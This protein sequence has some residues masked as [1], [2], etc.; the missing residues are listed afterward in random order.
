MLIRTIPLFL[1]FVLALVAAPTEVLA[2]RG[3]ISIV[4]ESRLLPVAPVPGADGDWICHLVDRT[5]LAFVPL[6]TSPGPYVYGAER[7][8]APGYAAMIAPVPSLKAMGAFPLHVPDTPTLTP[9][10]IAEGFAGLIALGLGL[11]FG[12][13]KFAMRAKRRDIRLQILG[14]GDGPVFQMIDVMCHAALADGKTDPSEVTAIRELARNLTGLDFQDLHITEMVSRA[15]RLTKPRDFVQFGRGL[16]AQQRLTILDGALSVILADG[17]LSPPEEEF[18]KNLTLGMKLPG[19]DVVGAVEA[20]LSRRSG[21]V[22][23]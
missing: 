6:W 18:L 8:D 7:C 13:L 21:A 19:Q 17:T 14:I 10:Q 12:G 9:L 15:D 1:T 23:A 2:K 4:Q 16:D 11:L 3:G 5:S 20:M 22:P